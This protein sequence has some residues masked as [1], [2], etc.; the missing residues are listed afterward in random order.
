MTVI[1]IRPHRWGWKVFDAPGVEPVFPPARASG[2]VRFVFWIQSASWNAPLR[3]TKQ[4]ENCDVPPDA[5]PSSKRNA[6]R[7]GDTPPPNLVLR[8][9]RN[10]GR[11]GRGAISCRILT[12]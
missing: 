5:R 8:K 11:L 3:L 9:R 4:I 12:Y 10:E 1:E 2:R 7:E 6:A